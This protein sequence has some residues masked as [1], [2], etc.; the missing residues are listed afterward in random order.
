M[1]QRGGLSFNPKKREPQAEREADIS[2]TSSARRYLT[3]ARKRGTPEQVAEAEKKVAA[4][5]PD[6]LIERRST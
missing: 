6:M 4:A 2:G 5:H 3:E 1:P